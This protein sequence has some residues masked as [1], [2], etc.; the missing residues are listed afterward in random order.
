MAFFSWLKRRRRVPA[1]GHEWVARY[2]DE[3]G[4]VGFVKGAVRGYRGPR[5]LAGS[6]LHG[7]ERAVWR[8]A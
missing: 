3:R 5:L 2:V 7:T 1:L 8:P 4:P 6:A